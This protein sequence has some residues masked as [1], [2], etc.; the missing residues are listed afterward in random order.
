[1]KYIAFLRGINVGGNNIIP[2]KEL[3]A[4][5]VG[6]GF[7]NV[8]TY[9]NS[10]NVLFESDL[11]EEKIREK[12]EVALKKKMGKD[13]PVV[14]RNSKELQ[15]ILSAN[16]FPE[17][18]PA[19]IGVVMFMNIV[20]AKFISGITSPGPEEIVPSGREIFIYFPDGMGR[21]KLKMPSKGEAGTVRN[22]NTIR[23][24]TEMLS[25]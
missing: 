14:I 5:C 6:I 17:A 24:L 3:A 15:S 7:K 13:V 19:K 23:K 20:P 11:H 16:P 22:I 10:G 21:S 4:I 18:V 25:D 9:I 2:M 8:R 12:T 1:M